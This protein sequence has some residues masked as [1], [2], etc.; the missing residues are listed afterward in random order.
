MRFAMAKMLKHAPSK[1]AR[2]LAETA[3]AIRVSA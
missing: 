1:K 2:L 3:V